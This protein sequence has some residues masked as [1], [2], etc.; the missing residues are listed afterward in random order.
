MVYSR[1]FARGCLLFF[2]FFSLFVGIFYLFFREKE[3]EEAY[4]VY[5]ALFEVRAEEASAF[6]IGDLLTDARGKEDAGVILAAEIY[7]AEREDAYGVYALADKRTL[8]LT[9][10]YRGKRTGEGLRVGTLTPRV[11]DAVDLFGKAKISGVC[12]KVRAV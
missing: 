11:G 12:L 10:G 6:A 3:K 1:R 7:A 9:L 5:T 2:A 4:V 8:L